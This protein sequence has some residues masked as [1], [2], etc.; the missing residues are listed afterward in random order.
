MP[1][2]PQ[3]PCVLYIAKHID[4]RVMYFYISNGKKSKS[5]QFIRKWFANSNLKLTVLYELYIYAV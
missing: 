3:K 2:V 4:S 1:C 5:D